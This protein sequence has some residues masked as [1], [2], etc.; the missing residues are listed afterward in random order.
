MDGFF[1]C[2]QRM[3]HT[4]AEGLE[5]SRQMEIYR[6]ASRVLSYEMDVLDRTAKMPRKLQFQILFFP[7][8]IFDIYYSMEI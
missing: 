7:F 2:V 4:P 5:I 3:V 6:M 8:Y 1:Q